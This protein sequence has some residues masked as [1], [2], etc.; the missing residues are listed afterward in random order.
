MGFAIIGGTGVYDPDMLENLREQTVDTPYG[1][2]AVRIGSY[3]GREVV[4]MNRHGAGHKLP[5]HKV[6]YRANIWALRKLGVRRVLG[7]AAVGS[8]NASMQPGDLVLASDFLDFTKS[9]VYTF[10]EGGD[11]GVVHVD[12]TEPYCPDLRQQLADIAAAEGLRCHDGGVYVCC[13][14]PRFETP[15]EIRMFQRLGGDLVGMTNV[16]EV[17]LAR[18]I[19]L[20]Y[21][22]VCMVTNLAA[23]ISETPLTHEEV[24]EVMAENGQRLRRLALGLLERLPGTTPSCGCQPPRPM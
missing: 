16:P 6:N 23:G 9:R 10:F 13:E 5:P 15:A 22:L 1:Q 3:K 14:G 19:G 8:L 11:D 2:T 17:V 12:V 4:F 21:S 18:E 24:L 7:T 20:C